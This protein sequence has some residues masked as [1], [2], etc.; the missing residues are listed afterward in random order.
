MNRTEE[1][2]RMCFTI[3]DQMVRFAKESLNKTATGEEDPKKEKTDINK[4][5]CLFSRASEVI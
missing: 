2:Y 4:R 1:R 5:K 3:I